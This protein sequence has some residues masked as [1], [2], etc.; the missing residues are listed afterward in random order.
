MVRPRSTSLPKPLL[1]MSFLLMLAAVFALPQAAAACWC[2][3]HGRRTG[4][5]SPL[6]TL[7]KGTPHRRDKGF[8]A[9]RVWWKS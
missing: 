9:R 1:W 5:A 8:S 3:R 2:A 6:G 7:T 4:G